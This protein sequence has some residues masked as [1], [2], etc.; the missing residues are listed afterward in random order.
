AG[1]RQARAGTGARRSPPRPARLRLLGQIL[2]QFLRRDG[3]IALVDPGEH[4]FDRH[5]LASVEGR[6]HPARLAEAVARLRGEREHRQ[7][8]I[9]AVGELAAHAEGLARHAE[10]DED[11]LSDLH[12]GLAPGVI[13]P[14]A[15]IGEGGAQELVAH[16]GPGLE[17]PFGSTGYSR[18]SS[19]AIWMVSRIFSLERLGS[20]AKPGNS[21]TQRCRSV[22][23]T[24]SGSTSGCFSTRRIAMSSMSV[25]LSGLGVSAIAGLLTSSEAR[26]PSPLPRAVPWGARRTTSAR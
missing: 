8:G 16:G 19:H 21:R 12:H 5:R 24:A 20:S 4:Q 23:R 6:R 9:E 2:H 26:G 1:R 14:G 18:S 7:R 22:K 10:E 15:R 11:L 25:H 3:A 13:F 17:T